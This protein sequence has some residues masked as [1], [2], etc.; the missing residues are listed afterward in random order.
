MGASPLEPQVLPD[1]LL[2]PRQQ[3]A[4]PSSTQALP[5]PPTLPFLPR[6]HRHEQLGS[7]R[8]V[9]QEGKRG[10]ALWQALDAAEAQHEQVLLRQLLH[11]PLLPLKAGDETAFILRGQEA[12]QQL[13]EVQAKGLQVKPGGREGWYHLRTTISEEQNYPFP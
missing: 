3:A 4:S 5:A 7:I 2:A 10:H 8:E 11:R 12:G 9:A 1:A 6:P 13:Q